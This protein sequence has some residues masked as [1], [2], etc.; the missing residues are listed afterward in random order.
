MKY[1]AVC[2]IPFQSRRP[3]QN[4]SEMKTH[5]FAIMEQSV[6]VANVDA[7]PIIGPQNVLFWATDFNIFTAQKG[8]SRQR[9]GKGAIRERFPL[10]KKTGKN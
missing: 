4:N 6:Y 7:K 3:L 8:T 2:E 10:E 9:S 1:V 5:D